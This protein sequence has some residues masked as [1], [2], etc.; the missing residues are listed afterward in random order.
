MLKVPTP[1]LQKAIFHLQYKA[2]LKFHSLLIP[3]AQKLADYPDWESSGLRVVLKHFAQHCSLAIMH[4]AIIY[5]QDS[6]DTQ[7]E[8]RRVEQALA[9]LPAAMEVEGFTRFGYR[10]QYL[11]PVDMP[12]DSL[13]SVLNVKLLSQDERLRGIMPNKVDDLMYR[14]D[15]SEEPYQFHFTIGPVRKREVPQYVT[16]NRV[17]HLK[18]ES[19]EEDY[20]TIVGNY[21]EAAI[22][23]DIDLYRSSD[24]LP[25]EDAGAFFETAR[26][27]V[28]SQCTGL[29]DYI[30]GQKVDS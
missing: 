15:S 27:R 26:E 6:G 23:T 13:V 11:I 2:A 20:S 30:F 29:C 8:K 16:Y 25:V 24:C 17:H 4:N 9:E 14:V 19:A 5:E 21:P 3:A 1:V 10:R 7:L 12:F 18:P 22:F 28:H